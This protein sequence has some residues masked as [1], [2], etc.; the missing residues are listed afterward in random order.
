MG[1]DHCERPNPSGEHEYSTTRNALVQLPQAPHLR[2]SPRRLLVR[3]ARGGFLSPSLDGGLP[4]LELFNPSRRSSSARLAF[5]ARFMGCITRPSPSLREHI[6]NIQSKAA[7]TDAIGS[8]FYCHPPAILTAVGAFHA[9]WTCCGHQSLRECF[10]VPAAT[11]IRLTALHC[12]RYVKNSF[13]Y[14]VD[15]G[16]KKRQEIAMNIGHCS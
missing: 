15:G 4:L 11:M 8:L 10:L 14:T 13:G 7:D 5:R 1:T 9:R 3:A 6:H 12:L 2:S 16:L